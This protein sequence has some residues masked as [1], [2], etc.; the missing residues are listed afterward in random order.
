MKQRNNF[1]KLLLL[2]LGSGKTIPAATLLRMGMGELDPDIYEDYRRR[3]RYKHYINE[4]FAKLEDKG[5]IGV[6]SKDGCKFARITPV[7]KQELLKYRL[8]EKKLEQKRWDGKWR[9][10]I[11]D[12]KEFKRGTRDKI[13]RELKKLGLVHLQDSVWVTPW[14]CEEVVS[15]L[16]TYFRLG[17]E[18]LHVVAEKIENDRWLRREFDL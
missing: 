13:R 4:T 8:G 12:I 16:K 10:I 3:S 6:V 15:L 14:E 18:V 5:L 11:F 9:L 7:G 17:L 2:I 1:V